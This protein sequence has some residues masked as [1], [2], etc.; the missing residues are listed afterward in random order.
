MIRS[1]L[2]IFTAIFLLGILHARAQESFKISGELRMRGEARNNADFNSDRLDG[3]A[4]VLNRLRLGFLRQFGHGLLIFAQLQDS[5]IW[6][7][8]GSSL[9]P[10]H[11][12]DLHQAYL[13]ID[14]PAKL[15]FLIRLGRQQLSF[16]SERLLG[17]YDW[18]NV[19]RA[20][21][22]LNVQ[23]GGDEQKLNLWL[24]QT[25]DHNAPTVARNQEFGGAYFSS[26][27]LLPMTFDAYVLVLYDARNFE[28]VANPAAPGDQEEPKKTLTLYTIGARL[29]SPRAQRFHYDLEG[30]YQTGQRGFR[31]ISAY[32]M[33]LHAGYTWERR[34]RPAIHAGYVFGSGDHD[35]NDE[36]SETFSNL[37]PDAHR[38]F[39]AMD[40][41]GWSNISATHIGAQISPTENFS[42]G[43]A[44][45]WLS[46]ADEQDAWYRAGGFNIG[47]P[48][49]FYRRA[50]PG[51]GKRLGNELDIYATCIYR[52][53]LNLQLGLSKFFV[54]EFVK[55]TGGMRADDSIFGYLSVAVKF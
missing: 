19:G 48:L 47:T 38:H 3:T 28:S 46:V 49:E 11:A 14:H 8:E 51:A 34:W 25:R 12:V 16:G 1:S 10:L 21:D 27:R 4:K 55:N 43:A 50:V 18:D 35:P 40:Y 24:A 53:H 37:F 33:A 42:C 29:G 2:A 23:F 41:A 17:S 36:K 44:W 20:F 7:E 13:E 52:E 32:G 5:R 6:G 15:P 31:D 22:A 39:G 45:H 26:S 9:T 54:G 30:A